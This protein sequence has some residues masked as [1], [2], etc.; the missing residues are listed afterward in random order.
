MQND[1]HSTEFNAVIRP[2]EYMRRQRDTSAGH[3][4]PLKLLVLSL[5]SIDLALV[6]NWK[7]WQLQS[8]ECLRPR[9]KDLAYELIAPPVEQPSSF[10]AVSVTCDHH[11]IQ[12]SRYSCLS[13]YSCGRHA[14]R[15]R[16]SVH[17]WLARVLRQRRVFQ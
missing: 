11:A 1:V 4:T 16:T 2:V 9:I 17:D 13:R 15:Q 6:I 5:M 14:H 7:F 12:A 8:A 3:S 10:N